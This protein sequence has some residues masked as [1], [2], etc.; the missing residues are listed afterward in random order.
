MVNIQILYCFVKQ[1]KR[2]RKEALMGRLHTD[3]VNHRASQ[4]LDKR[5][6]GGHAPAAPDGRTERK[7]VYFLDFF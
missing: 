7:H 1:A 5:H 4:A 2:D 6:A 3:C